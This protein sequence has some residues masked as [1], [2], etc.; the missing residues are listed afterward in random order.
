MTFDEMFPPEGKFTDSNDDREMTVL[1]PGEPMEIA[2]QVGQRV[3]VWLHEQHGKEAV[4]TLVEQEEF[5]KDTRMPPG[6]RRALSVTPGEHFLLIRFMPNDGW[7]QEDANRF[8]AMVSQYAM[9]QGHRICGE[10]GE[11]WKNT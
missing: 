6:V 10:E 11:W 4:Y 8:G 5:A 2:T 1:L 7:T 9:S 3:S